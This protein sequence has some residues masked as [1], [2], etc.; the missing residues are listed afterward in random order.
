MGRHGNPDAGPSNR[1]DHQGAEQI[2]QADHQTT[3][4]QFCDRTA[5]QFDPNAIE[6]ANGERDPEERDAEEEAP[7]VHLPPEELPP[8][9]AY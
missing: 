3:Q 4:R 6:L 5:G 2:R 7:F 9:L 1:A 8:R